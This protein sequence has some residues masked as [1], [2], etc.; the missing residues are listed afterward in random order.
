MIA[1]ITKRRLASGSTAQLRR[2]GRGALLALA[3]QASGA[4]LAYASAIA[5]ARWLGSIEYGVYVTM[6]ATVQALTVLATLGLQMTALRFV[7][8]YRARRQPASLRG[9]VRFAQMT[10]LAVGLALAVVSAPVVLLVARAA[11]KDSLPFLIALAIVPLYGLLSVQGEIGRASGR[12]LEAYGPQMIARPLVVLAGALLLERIGALD[13]YSAL[14][15]FLAATLVACVVQLV[16]LRRDEL[17]RVAVG[18]DARLA[19]ER[20]S[21]RSSWLRVSAPLLVVSGAL[22][23]LAQIDLLLV[24]AIDG[25][26]AAGVYNAASRTTLLVS[27]VLIAINAAAAPMLVSLHARGETREFARLAR[28]ASHLAFWPALGAAALLTLWGELPLRLFGEEFVRDAYLPLVI[29]AWG[30]VFNASCGPVGYLLSFT[31]HESVSARVYG[32]AALIGAGA[33]AAGVL[34]AGGVG[35]AAAISAAVIAWNLFLHRLCASRLGIRPAV[36]YSF[37]P[38]RGDR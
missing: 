30:Q 25:A 1:T 26:H 8:R 12:M 5:L 19:S 37:L 38:G 23:V 2:L 27:G 3:I 14:L 35:A 20:A 36:I 9:F 31:G 28:Q 4:L 33:V 32:V 13:V 16:M 29:L 6:I 18:V 24:G 21:E 15:A 34:V 10:P 7:P 22:F 11:D 17:L